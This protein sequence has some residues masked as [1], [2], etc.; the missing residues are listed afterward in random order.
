M[1]S[2]V[3][4]IPFFLLAVFASLALG[5][6]VTVPDPGTNA[7]GFIAELFKFVMSGQ[8]SLVVGAALVLVVHVLR[9]LPN[10]LG[11]GWIAWL[12]DNKWGGWLVSFGASAIG[13]LATALLAGQ[14]VTLK[15]VF[16][17][18]A[19]ALTASG[20]FELAKDSGALK[21]TSK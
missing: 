18:L 14:T 6:P 7:G 10:P 11:W 13:A 9:K 16:M 8:W 17:A 4:F 20:I 5:Q 3:Y 19:N 21:T 1:R 2:I 12:K 15:L